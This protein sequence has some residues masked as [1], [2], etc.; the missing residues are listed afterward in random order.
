MRFII[1]HVIGVKDLIQSDTLTDMIVIP[2]ARCKRSM[3]MI[4]MVNLIITLK[5]RS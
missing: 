3:L 1:D 2:T 5:S 4:L